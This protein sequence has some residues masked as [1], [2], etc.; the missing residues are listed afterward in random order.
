M[1]ARPFILLA[2]GLLLGGVALNVCLPRAKRS[3][4]Q[5]KPA[6]NAP[7]ATPSPSRRR[8]QRREADLGEPLNEAPS[9]KSLE[10]H[11]DAE[12]R[13]LTPE[14]AEAYVRDNQRSASSLLA[15]SRVFGEKAYLRE[16]MAKFPKDPLVAF[17]AYFCNGPYDNTKPASPERRQWLEAMK[18][19]DPDNALPNYL[20]A[21]DDFK[22]GKTELALQAL[23]AAANKP[24]FDSYMLESLQATEEAYR[25]AGYSEGDA[26]SAASW[27]LLLPHLSE[28]KQLAQNI[29]D[30]AVEYQN[31]G[32]TASAQNLLQ[33]GLSLGQQVGG[34]GE[35]P[36]INTLVGIAIQKKLL[37]VMDPASPYLDTSTTVQQQIDSLNQYRESLRSIGPQVE[38]ILPRLTEPDRISYYDRLRMFGEPAAVQW[39]VE[40]Y[41]LK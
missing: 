21:R 34:P 23:E 14:R 36:L 40:K 16:A 2:T 26:K 10:A 9:M 27:G 24:K 18:L 19:S 12:R 17:D 39:A 22:A 32:D 3:S 41:G 6:L 20:T 11:F 15:A 28:T 7:D 31:A 5:S 25:A 8:P 29:T 37:G 38:A 13:K 33:L 35:F 30:L 1:R 4:A